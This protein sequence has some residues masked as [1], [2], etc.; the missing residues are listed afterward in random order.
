MQFRDYSDYEQEANKIR[1]END[2]L[3]DEF[4]AWLAESG[5]K[6]KTIKKHT[7]NVWF[8]IYEYLLYE[9]AIRPQEGISA[10]GEFFNWFFPRKAM[11][12]NVKTTRETVTSLKK[13]YRFLADTGSVGDVEYQR[14][15]AEVKNEMPEWLEHYRDLDD[16]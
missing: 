7:G 6:E 9:D 14:L 15:L 1:A 10:V 13:F 11:W 4:K 8:Y 5:L 2:A 12:S 16:W 3:L